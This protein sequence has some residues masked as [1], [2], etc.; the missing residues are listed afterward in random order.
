MLFDVLVVC[1]RRRLDGEE[2]A[3]E[4]ARGKGCR[5]TRRGGSFSTCRLSHLFLPGL[6]QCTHADSLSLRVCTTG[7]LGWSDR[8]SI[9][10]S[11]VTSRS[12]VRSCTGPV[13]SEVRGVRIGGVGSAAAAAGRGKRFARNSVHSHRTISFPFNLVLSLD[14]VKGSRDNAR[15]L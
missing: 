5:W 15:I 8:R 14:I 9:A 11:Q 4:R 13:R 6:V 7:G 2:R 1:D 10:S 3:S 12:N